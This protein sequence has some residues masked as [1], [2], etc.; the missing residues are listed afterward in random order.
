M[1]VLNWVQ[2]GPIRASSVR[3]PGESLNQ[4]DP[5]PLWSL[6]PSLKTGISVLNKGLDFSSQSGIV[7]K[8]CSR[9]SVFRS[10]VN[11]LEQGL[12]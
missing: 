8:S 3:D 11:V 6:N 4:S 5:P 2:K 1:K 12:Y 10:H 7:M 9:M